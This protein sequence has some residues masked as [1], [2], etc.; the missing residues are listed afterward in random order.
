[1]KGNLNLEGQERG[2]MKGSCGNNLKGKGMGFL[3]GKTQKKRECGYWLC[4][5]LVEQGFRSP[6][7]SRIPSL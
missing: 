3:D 6:K 4:G 7:V 2:N 5:N 1:M